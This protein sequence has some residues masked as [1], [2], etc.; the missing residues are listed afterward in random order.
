MTASSDTLRSTQQPPSPAGP[1]FLTGPRPLG[2]R[3]KNWERSFSLVPASLTS[4]FSEHILS[5]IP[6]SAPKAVWQPVP[7]R[8]EPVGLLTRSSLQLVGDL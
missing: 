3:W 5:L 2:A 6:P 8:S 7:G 1:S 4:P